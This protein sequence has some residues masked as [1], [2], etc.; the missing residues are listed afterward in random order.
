MVVNFLNSLMSSAPSTRGCRKRSAAPKSAPLDAAL[1]TFSMSL[2]MM[3]WLDW[4]LTLVA[5]GYPIAFTLLFAYFLA[6][7]MEIEGTDVVGNTP[8][9]FD[10]FIK[11]EMTK[12]GKVVRDAGIRN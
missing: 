3:L 6:R 5:S 2:A 4:R 7:R 9:Q 8:Q 11:S 10:A 1:I 12:W